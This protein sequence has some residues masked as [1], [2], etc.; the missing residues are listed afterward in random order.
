LIPL[1]HTTPPYRPWHSWGGWSPAFLSGGLCLSPEQAMR[2]IWGTMWHWGGF[3][4]STSVSP[5]NIYFTIR[6]TLPIT[7]A[8]WS[9]AWTVFARSKDGI[10]GS[11]PTQG[12]DVR[13]VCVYSLCCVGRG[14]ATADPPSKESYRLYIGS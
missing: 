1:Y 7:V 9:K 2:E 10:V 4:P 5:A 13:I 8:A 14:F 6:S 11:N 3:S 12:M